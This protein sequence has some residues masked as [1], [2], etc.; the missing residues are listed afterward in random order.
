[1]TFIEFETQLL[2][3]G[4]WTVLKL[5]LSISKELPSRGM[6]MI[7]GTINNID[8]TTPLEPDGL[9]SHWFRISDTFRDEL[10]L[11][12]GDSVSLSIR[13]T[14]NW[15]EPELP[16]DLNHALKSRKVENQ[17]NALTTKADGNGF[18]GSVLPVIHKLVKREYKPPVPS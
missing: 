13:P 18:D 16:E 3:Y 14:K 8:F 17:W 1:M 15:I 9:G 7:E 2:L 4:S 11:K 10:A 6:V 12:V 5:P